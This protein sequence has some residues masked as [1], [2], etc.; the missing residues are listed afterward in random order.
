MANPNRCQEPR[1]GGGIC[2]RLAP[3]GE[4]RCGLHAGSERMAMSET[5]ENKAVDPERAAMAAALASKEPEP[6]RPTTM[7][8]VAGSKPDPLGVEGRALKAAL[9]LLAMEQKAQEERIAARLSKRNRGRELP[10]AET[11]MFMPEV[12]DIAAVPEHL[13]EDGYVYRWVS[14]KDVEGRPSALSVRRWQGVG[15]TEVCDPENDNQPVEDILG[16]LMK[17]PAANWAANAIRMSPKG[18][19]DNNELVR[20]MSD[21]VDRTNKQLGRTV[22]NLVVSPDHGSREW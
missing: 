19:F 20:E 4:D 13:K 14:Q 6:S 9:P 18:A 21:A 17:I 10:P 16:K 11:F 22:G 7:T 3:K 12:V 2:N 15:A 8:T 5:T 1:A